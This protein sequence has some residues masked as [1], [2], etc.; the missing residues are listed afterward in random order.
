MRHGAAVDQRAAVPFHRRQ[1]A[2]D[3]GA[4]EQRG[5]Q[6]AVVQQHR[7]A[8]HQVR[9]D[10]DEGDRQVLDPG[11]QARAPDE[12]AQAGVG[13]QAGPEGPQAE[14]EDLAAPQPRPGQGQRPGGG[15]GVRGAATCATR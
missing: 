12:P 14:R 4:R 10:R 11:R 6:V 1:D 7:F 2:G 8:G 9:G 13:E 5:L 3:R 15:A